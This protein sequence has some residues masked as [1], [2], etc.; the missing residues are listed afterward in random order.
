MRH[1]KIATD[2]ARYSL[3]SVTRSNRIP[4][5]RILSW[6]PASQKQVLRIGSDIRILLE[7]GL[8]KIKH[9]DTLAEAYQFRT[10]AADQ[11]QELL[12]PGE[13]SEQF[14]GNSTRLCS[15]VQGVENQNG[16]L[17]STS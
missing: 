17:L 1:E 7:L 12:I 2:C 11:N 8:V 6:L 15:F 16:P 9:L 13:W 14:V 4:V 10:L 5:V 3:R